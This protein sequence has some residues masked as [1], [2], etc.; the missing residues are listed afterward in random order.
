MPSHIHK[1]GP[2]SPTMNMTSMIDVIFLLIVFF[3]LVNTIITEQA[4]PMHVPDLEDSQTRELDSEHRITVNIVPVDWQRGQRDQ[5]W[6]D[7][8]P[9]PNYVRIGLADYPMDDLNAMVEDLKTWSDGLR[10]GN[11][12]QKEP[13]VL[14]RA[15][16]CLDY[17]SVQ[18]VLATITKAGIDKVHLVAQ[19]PEQP[20]S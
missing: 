7:W 15:D 6:L 10:K 17:A 2:V 13:E 16:G 14:L 9:H 1:R 11:T 8:D 3:M 12:T 5:D 18:Q 4:V 20:Q 19:L